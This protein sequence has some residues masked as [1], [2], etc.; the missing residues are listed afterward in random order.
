MVQPLIENASD[1]LS[2]FSR[3]ALQAIK[4][5]EKLILDEES[6]QVLVY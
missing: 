4:E 5:W 6:V 3:P 1:G 2:E